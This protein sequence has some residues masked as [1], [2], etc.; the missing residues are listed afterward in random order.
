MPGA[1]NAELLAGLDWSW[2]SQ[3]ACRGADPALF[4]PETEE[5]AEPARA[6]C[7]TCPVRVECLAFALEAGERFGVWGGM[8]ER[9]RAALPEEQRRRIIAEARRARARRL[10]A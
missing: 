3:A 6:I 5:G 2:Q 7:R 10:A 4:F 8:T 1:P 9:E